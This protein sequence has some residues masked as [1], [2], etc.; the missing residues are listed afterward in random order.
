MDKG[1]EKA[2]DCGALPLCLAALG[3]REGG[4]RGCPQL[5][6]A[7]SPLIRDGVLIGVSGGDCG[8]PCTPFSGANVALTVDWLRSVV[9][10]DE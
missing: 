7:G 10:G 4:G 9:A 5:R 8:E 1:V 2:G 3:A 6:C